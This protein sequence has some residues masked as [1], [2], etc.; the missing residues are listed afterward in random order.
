MCTCT[1]RCTSMLIYLLPS[2]SIQP[3]HTVHTVPSLFNRVHDKV[4]SAVN[5]GGPAA[6]ALFRRAVANRLW[7]LRLP[8]R[9]PDGRLDPP[10]GWPRPG[11]G[12]DAAGVAG[13]GGSA[14]P[15]EASIAA[16]RALDSVFDRVV[17][18]KTRARLGGRVR[19]LI[20]GAS[21]LGANVVDLLRCCFTPALLEGGLGSGSPSFSSL[22]L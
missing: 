2:F 17:F 16:A 19:L 20:T 21:P 11:P 5:D 12:E 15:S 9:A 13:A 14:P 4:L 6:R 3:V 8:A 10:P 7:L 1:N 18:H 22:S